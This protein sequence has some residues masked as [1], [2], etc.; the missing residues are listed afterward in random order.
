MILT[1][2]DG[3]PF[4]VQVFRYFYSVYIMYTNVCLDICGP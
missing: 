2:C 1:F 3:E 4:E